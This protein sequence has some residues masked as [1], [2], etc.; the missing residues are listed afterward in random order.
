MPGCVAL[1]LGSRADKGGGRPGERGG[2]T[3]GEGHSS[4]TLLQGQVKD[5]GLPEVFRL[6]KLGCK[7]GILK[8]VNGRHWADFH[9]RDGQ[10]VDAAASGGGGSLT[11]RLERAHVLSRQEIASLPPELRRGDDPPGLRAYLQDQHLVSSEELSPLVHAHIHDVMFSSCGWGAAEFHFMP[12]A[13]SPPVAPV[14]SLDVE[15]VVME[16]MRRLDEWRMIL[17]SL[18]GLEKVPHLATTLPREA[19]TLSQTAW[20]VVSLIDGRRDINTIAQEAQLDRYQT[21]RTIHGLAG[22]ELVATRE[23]RLD[24]LGQKVAVALRGPIDIYN[25]AFLTSACTS[26]ISSHLRLESLGGEEAEIRLSAGVRETEVESCLVYFS[27]ARTPLAAVKGMALE[28]SGYVVLVNVKSPV[29]RWWSPA[30][31]SS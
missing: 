21:V 7:T 26:D 28:T 16:A 6:L 15:P 17:D 24:L 4:T 11:E 29:T 18:G 22:A 19:V 31:T 20:H 5:I 30:R 12:A 13:A 23:P 2:A 9:L 8:V 1:G 14:V 10:V 27:E 3:T 25:L